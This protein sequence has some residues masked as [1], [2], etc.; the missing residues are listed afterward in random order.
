MLSGLCCRQAWMDLTLRLP[1][2]IV[3]TDLSPIQV[4]TPD[5]CTFEIEDADEDW[6]F[7]PNYFSMVHTRNLVANPIP[8]T[9][10]ILTAIY[11]SVE[12]QTGSASLSS[13]TGTRTHPIP[14]P[15]RQ[16]L[17]ARRQNRTLHADGWVEL[18]EIPCLIYSDNPA[19]PPDLPF[20]RAMAQ[21]CRA[22][23]GVCGEELYGF[24]DL[25]TTAGFVD[26]S[27]TRY[28]IP[29][30]EWPADVTERELGRYNMLNFLEGI[31]GYALAVCGAG[32]SGSE[33]P[34]EAV[35]KMK[36]LV[37]KDIKNKKARLY[38]NLWVPPSN[39]LRD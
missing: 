38:V 22:S 13:R 5:N 27:E 9:T 37:E 25:M 12:S 3:G 21:Y 17:T 20:M 24:K 28:R 18:H 4:A 32:D 29:I 7:P 2:Q 35:Q 8:R 6:L 10:D 19:T 33:P 11:S 26:V 39:G 16:E 14:S 34:S 36:K 1:H 31:E 30:S 15:G 23:P